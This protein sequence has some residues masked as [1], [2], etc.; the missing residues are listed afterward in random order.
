VENEEQDHLEGS[1][2]SEAEKE[3]AHGIRATDVEAP[4]I[5][6]VMVHHGKEKRE[7]PWDY[8]ENLD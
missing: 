7:K 6:G 2:P 3:A 4:A 5:Q 8:G 1:S